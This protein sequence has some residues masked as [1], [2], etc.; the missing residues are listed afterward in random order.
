MLQHRRIPFQTRECP[1]EVVVT[2]RIRQ[3]VPIWND[4]NM[5]RKGL[6]TLGI[7]SG[8]IAR[9]FAVAPPIEEWGRQLRCRQLPVICPRERLVLVY[10]RQWLAFAQHLLQTV[11]MTVDALSIRCPRSILY[12]PRHSAAEQVR[13]MFI[14]QKSEVSACK[15]DCDGRRRAVALWSF[16]ASTHALLS[17]LALRST[18]VRPSWNLR[19]CVLSYV[20]P[21]RPASL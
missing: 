4:L 2:N 7:F 9:T 12:V 19:V 1:P 17:T 11:Q 10:L 20:T 3:S 15:G 18:S 13:T 21:G 6:R 8:S 14:L 5:E 16:I